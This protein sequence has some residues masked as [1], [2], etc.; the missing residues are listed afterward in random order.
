MYSSLV[1]R[2]NQLIEE[3]ER[4]RWARSAPL[5]LDRVAEPE[6]EP[7]VEDGHQERDQRRRVVARVGAG[8]RARDTDGRA[9]ADVV[10]IAGHRRARVRASPPRASSSSSSRSLSHDACAGR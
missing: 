8:R 2:P 3:V 1:V 10:A 5:R 9:Q 7:D 4:K 6:A